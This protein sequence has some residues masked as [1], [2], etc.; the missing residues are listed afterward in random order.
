MIDRFWLAVTTV[1]VALSATVFWW[2]RTDVEP[3]RLVR[4]RSEVWVLPEDPRPAFDETVL[5]PELIGTQIFGVTKAP[6]KGA[7]EPATWM[8]GAVYRV[9][10]KPFALVRFSEASRQDYSVTLMDKL[11]DGKIV[12]EIRDSLLIVRDGKKRVELALRQSMPMPE[13]GK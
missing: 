5:S 12:N 3:P 7:P 2:P 11:P 1:A 13:A 9:G 8:I 4:A 6:Q 10:K